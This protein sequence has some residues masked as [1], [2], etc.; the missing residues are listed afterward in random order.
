[1]VKGIYHSAAGMLAR[2]R[3]LE[4]VAN[5]LAN[6][7][8]TGFRQENVTFRSTLNSTL[9][10]SDLPV[11]AG[12]KFVDAERGT[13]P[14]SA[15]GA[16]QATGNPLDVA[17]QGEGY[18][19][20]ETEAGEAYTRDGR[21]QLNEAGE[22]VTYSGHRVQTENGTLTVPQG[23]LRIA[24]DGSLLVSL[25]GE[26]REQILDRLRIVAFPD[27]GRMAHLQDGYYSANQEPVDLSP[28]H[29]AVGYLEESNVNVV[30]EMV[31]M[32]EINQTYEASARAMQTQD[33]TLGKAVNEVGKV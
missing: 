21:F 20:V 9:M 16:L 25:P 18:F 12:E 17:I 33:T 5:N 30:A 8:T 6:A 27:A 26:N 14:A 23:G 19:V 29:L 24:S 7:R 10:K 4:V 3:H 32:I 2:Q 22:L 13:S 28:I 15:Q 11:T 31:K 1:M